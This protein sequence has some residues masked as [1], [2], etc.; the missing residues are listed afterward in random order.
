V[1]HD[2]CRGRIEATGSMGYGRRTAE[3]D[4]AQGQRM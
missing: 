3:L 4:F 2:G 1:R